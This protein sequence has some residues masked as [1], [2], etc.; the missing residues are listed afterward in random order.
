MF[1]VTLFD[2]FFAVMVSVLTRM[3]LGRSASWFYLHF[4]SFFTSI[5]ETISIMC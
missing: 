5:K 2:T 3:L 4:D 1:N